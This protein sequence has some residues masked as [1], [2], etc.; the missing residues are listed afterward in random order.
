MLLKNGL[1]GIPVF[2]LSLVKVPKSILSK[3]QNACF[4]FI[5]SGAKRENVI[6][7]VKC[8]KLAKAKK[9]GG[10]V[11]KDLNLFSNALDSKSV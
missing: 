9:F 10:W 1:E 11:L 8:Q 5:W 3:I 7:L 4:I 2:W 6:P